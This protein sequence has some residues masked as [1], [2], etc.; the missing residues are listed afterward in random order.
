[1]RQILLFQGLVSLVASGYG[2]CHHMVMMKNAITEYLGLLC[3]AC[4]AS[5]A[6]LRFFSG[7][8]GSGEPIVEIRGSVPADQVMELALR[9]SAA[10]VEGFGVWRMD[11]SSYG[12]EWRLQRRLDGMSVS[13]DLEMN[14][15][16]PSFISRRL[17]AAGEL[18]GLLEHLIPLVEI[19]VS[20][21][22]TFGGAAAGGSRSFDPPIIG[23]SPSIVSLRSDIRKIAAGEI[24][25]LICGESGTG[26]EL[27]ARNIHSLGPRAGGPFIAVNCLEMPAG[28][29][30]G[31][32]FGSVRG[33]YT[34]ADRDREGLIEAAVGGT[35]FLDEIGELSVHLQAALL[36]VLQEKEVRRLGEGKSKK[37]DVRFV[38]ATN[39]D[40]EELVRSG[41]F[42]EDLYYRLNAV[43]VIIPPL[44]E[45]NEDIPVLTAR[46]LGESSFRLRGRTMSITAGAL[47]R[48]LGHQWPGNVRELRNEI[49][50]VVTMNPGSNRITASMLEIPEVR[51]GILPVTDSGFEAGTMPEAVLVLERKMIVKA[52]EGFGGNRTR[53]AK[54]LGITRQGLL[55]KLKRMKID[56]DRYR[57]PVR[58]IT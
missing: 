5:A 26:K 52:L 55:K 40:L 32:L 25:V 11:G 8:E 46:F 36:R 39:R 28:L 23:I 7:E 3:G 49:E 34:G 20:G 10:F 27:V 53:T 4:G 16:S 31:E 9:E 1:M 56:P 41:H 24:P 18:L 22:E 14:E 30:Q 12:N 48:L 21:T 43:R 17:A 15:R 19:P 42:R 51:K 45:R 50:R 33:A 2:Y 57:E 6:R 37:V 35:F 47:S 54:A 44:R 13:L 29:L 38:F 58:S